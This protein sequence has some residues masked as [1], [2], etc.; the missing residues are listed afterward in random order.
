MASFYSLV[1][2]KTEFRIIEFDPSRWSM[3]KM[4][5]SSFVRTN[6]KWN[7]SLPREKGGLL[8]KTCH[9]M[10]AN[11]CMVEFS[12][13]ECLCFWLFQCAYPAKV[14]YWTDFL[15][16]PWLTVSVSHI[17]TIALWQWHALVTY[18]QEGKNRWHHQLWVL[19]FFI[20]CVYVIKLDYKY[21]DP[22]F[23]TTGWLQG[24]LRFDQMSAGISLEITG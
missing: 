9:A 1:F 7:N 18:C 12:V 8:L 4:V 19:N 3:C 10:S 14:L 6:Q 20:P 5:R 11:L 21:R 2:T 16:G 23:K 13:L 15:L 24:W 22:G 17:F